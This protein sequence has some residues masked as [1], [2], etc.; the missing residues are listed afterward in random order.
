ML[1]TVTF[2]VIIGAAITATLPDGQLYIGFTG[3]GFMLFCVALRKD[4][5]SY[6]VTFIAIPPAFILLYLV[7]TKMD[8]SMLF[9]A[10][11][12]SPTLVLIMGVTLFI[13]F[14]IE[15]YF[16]NSRAGI[17]DIR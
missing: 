15:R 13:Y 16:F 10:N 8:M 9:S 6:K 2:T 1:T 5:L 12:N 11:D 7:T 4:Y 14:L 3:T 17:T